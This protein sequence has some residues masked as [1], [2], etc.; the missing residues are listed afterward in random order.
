[1]DIAVISWNL[2]K[3]PRADFEPI[4]EQMEAA[5][6]WSVACLQE[7]SAAQTTWLAEADGANFAGHRLIVGTAPSVEAGVDQRLWDTALL[8]HS[9]LAHLICWTGRTSHSTWAAISATTSGAGRTTRLFGSLH[10]PAC[11]RADVYDDCLNEVLCLVEGYKTSTD[12]NV[13]VILGVDANVGFSPQYNPFGG[14]RVQPRGQPPDERAISFVGFL[15][16]LGLLPINI[17]SSSANFATTV[18]EEAFDYWTHRC[19]VTKALFQKDFICM[20]V[21]MALSVFAA[22]ARDLVPRSDHRAIIGGSAAPTSDEGDF[23]PYKRKGRRCWNPSL[24]AIA[25]LNKHVR[26][27]WARPGPLGCS[28]IQDTLADFSQHGSAVASAQA[29][30]DKLFQSSTKRPSRLEALEQMLRSNLDATATTGIREKL[31]AEKHKWSRARATARAWRRKIVH[32]KARPCVRCPPCITSLSG[33]SAT[34]A[35]EWPAILT[36]HFRAKYA[37]TANSNEVQ[38]A[39][40]LRLREEILSDDAAYR[41]EGQS[42]HIFLSLGDFLRSRARLRLDKRGGEDGLVARH[43][44]ALDWTSSYK[45]YEAFLRRANAQDV[46]AVAGWSEQFVQMQYKRGPLVALENYRDISPTPI[47]L[48]VFERLLAVTAARILLP[49]PDFQGLSR[50]RATGRYY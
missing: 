47:L 24:E 14:D 38:V 8:V 9:R 19:K 3:C 12:A 33:G 35:Q 20:P 31:A 15:N 18:P 26:H 4:V 5:S 37:D 29:S 6:V 40:L 1:M 30:R 48:Q 42:R 45:I 27:A 46:E 11:G 36:Q 21:A 16:C 2:D 7:A 49:L 17:F 34:A 32:G 43:L 28:E 13:D 44:L 10:C 41:L 25:E 23:S 39:T 50:R 22:P